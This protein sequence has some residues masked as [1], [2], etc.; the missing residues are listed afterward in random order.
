MTCEN[1]TDQEGKSCFPAYGLA[2]HHHIDSVTFGGTIFTGEVVD[3]FTP[4]ADDKRMGTWW[5]VHCEEGK[6]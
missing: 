1:C 5:C 2:P 3:G 4:D 6:P